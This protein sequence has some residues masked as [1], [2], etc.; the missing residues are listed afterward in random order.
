MSGVQWIV[1]VRR[2]RAA[3]LSPH[4][5]VGPLADPHEVRNLA[6]DPQHKDKLEEMKAKLKVF[7][8]RTKDPWLL[9]WDYG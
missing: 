7:Q 9:K 1:R 2:M 6:A 4:A 5:R 3:V 8:K